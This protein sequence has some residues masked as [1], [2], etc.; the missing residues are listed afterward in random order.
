MMKEKSAPSATISGVAPARTARWREWIARAWPYALFT[1]LLLYGWRNW[2]LTTSLPGYNDTLEIVWVLRWYADALRGLHG[3]ATYPLAFFPAGWHVASYGQGLGMYL[4]L[5][6]LYW[7]GGAAFAYNVVALFS[8]PLAFA[9]MYQ[10]AGRFT[11]VHREES[12]RTGTAFRARLPAA[13]AALLFT[14]W[15]FRWFRI[16]GHLNILVASALLP[17]MAWALD[18]WLETQRPAA[19]SAERNARRWRP[20]GWLALV[21]VLWAATIPNSWYFAWIGGALL[22]AWLAGYLIARRIG[23]RTAFAGIALPAVVALAVNAPWLAWFMRERAAAN[24][25]PYD[26]SEVSLWDSSL[27]ALL[28]PNVFHPW[29]R[30]VA[31]WIYRGPVNEPGLTNLGLAACLLAVLGLWRAWKDRRWWPVLVCA[32]A[33]LVLALGLRLHWNGEVVQWAALRPL[34]TVIWQL[35]HALKPDVFAPALPPASFATAVPLPGLLLSAVVP[36]IDRARVFAR[37]ALIGSIGV[38]LLVALGLGQLRRNWVQVLAAAVLVFEVLP[39]P[40]Q[41]VPFPPPSHPAFAWL[42]EQRIAPDGII[43]LGSWQQ[44]LLYVTSGGSALWATG[45]HGKPTVAG[46]GSNWPAYVTFLSDWLQSSPHAFLNPDFVPLLQSYDLRYLVFHVAG[47]T[48]RDLLEEAAQNPQLQNMHCF[49]PSTASG[50]WPYPIC[51]ME[52]P[53]ADAAFNVLFREGWSGA[54]DWG[55]WVEGTEARSVWVAT[56]REPVELVLNAFPLCVPGRKQSVSVEVNGLELASHEWQ[57][58]EAWTGRIGIPASRVYVGWNEIVLRSNYALRPV[59]VSNG[60]GR[61]S[62]LLSIGITRMEVAQDAAKN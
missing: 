31:R 14:F 55:R 41:E 8:F 4:P 51:I 26:A 56:S 1:A 61:D 38:Y 58:C 16:D 15:G 62:R 53:L 57:D 25:L 24:V 35:G 37:Y 48:A 30:A 10:L 59:D 54:E 2:R 22:A 28:A 60:Q 27:N 50:P 13:I 23:L 6:P 20:Y 7:L 33:G 42:A 52:I 36:V 45:L 39:P 29:L 11:F 5:L 17:W 9:G 18:R 3:W 44:D 49:Q 34:N 43:D 46:T 19:A 40:S 32:G 21:G 12:L 47:S